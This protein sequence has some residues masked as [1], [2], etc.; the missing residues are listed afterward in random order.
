M[1]AASFKSLMVGD[2]EFFFPRRS[3][4]RI[5]RNVGRETCQNDESRAHEPVVTRGFIKSSQ[6][7]S[8]SSSSFLARVLVPVRGEGAGGGGRNSLNLLKI[9]GIPGMSF[10]CRLFRSGT[11]R[12]PVLHPVRAES[13]HPQGDRRLEQLAAGLL[14]RSPRAVPR[15]RLSG[16]DEN[17]SSFQRSCD[18][19]SARELRPR[20]WKLYLVQ[21]DS[22]RRP[23]V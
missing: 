5:F 10:C 8:C 6:H 18:C 4:R 3:V 19:R 21:T 22:G 12:H 11:P 15:Q 14:P 2:E 7:P 1:R 23:V 13:P 16:Y 9:P 17:A 20:C